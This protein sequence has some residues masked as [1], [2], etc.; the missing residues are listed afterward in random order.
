MLT[1]LKS[2]FSVENEK[3]LACLDLCYQLQWAGEELE[4]QTQKQVKDRLKSLTTTFL[5]CALPP[6]ANFA[7]CK[8]YIALNGMLSLVSQIYGTYLWLAKLAADPGKIGGVTGKKQYP[9]HRLLSFSNSVRTSWTDCSSLIGSETALNPAL[10]LVML[11]A[12]ALQILTWLVLDAVFLAELF[13]ALFWLCP[14]HYSL[15]DK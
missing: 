2:K 5:L 9:C 7:E 14:I 6:Y 1:N 4:T 3:L 13:V 10:W 11:P 8:L 15:C 12:A